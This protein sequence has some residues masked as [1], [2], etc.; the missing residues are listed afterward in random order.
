MNFKE[1]LEMAITNPDHI[2]KLNL[3][4]SWLKQ[5]GIP[6]IAIGG[7]AVV[8]YI[9]GSRDKTDVDFLVNDIT[10]ILAACKAENLITKPLALPQMF[11][12]IHVPQLD[13]DFIKVKEP[14]GGIITSTAQKEM[15]GNTIFPVISPEALVILKFVSGRDKDLGDAFSLLQ[16]GLLD[17]KKYIQ[18][19][20]KIRGVEDI[21]SY[22]EIIPSKVQAV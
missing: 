13:T 12:G 3:V 1:F 9:T 5:H 20:R 22:A 6:A 17:K 11:N 2:S 18:L 21:A 4:T 16:S 10:P 7:T 14:L 19:A 15:L 8:H